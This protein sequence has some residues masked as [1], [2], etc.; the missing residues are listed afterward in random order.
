MCEHLKKLDS[1]LQAKGI[2]ETFRGEAWSNNAREWVYYDCVLNLVS[3]RREYDF[4]D[5]ITDHVNDDQRSGTESGFYCELC[6]DAVMGHHPKFASGKV[7]V[8]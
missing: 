5:F 3:L 8:Q 2:K 1:D 7:L 6:Q 4:P